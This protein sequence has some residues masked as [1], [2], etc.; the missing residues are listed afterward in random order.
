M[1]YMRKFVLIVSLAACVWMAEWF[2]GRIFYANTWK[3]GLQEGKVETS[4]AFI[5][6]RNVTE[7][8]F[9]GVYDES[10][11]MYPLEGEDGGMYAARYRMSWRNRAKRLEGW[12]DDYKVNYILKWIDEQE[13]DYVANATKPVPSL[14]DRRLTFVHIG[15]MHFLCYNIVK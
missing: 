6:E 15:K 14:Q 1:M 13:K 5:S 4:K 8:R 9:P 2:G 7:C 11:P 10:K 3:S 12:E